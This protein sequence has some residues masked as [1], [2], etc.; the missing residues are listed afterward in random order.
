MHGFGERHT[1]VVCH[2]SRIPVLSHDYRRLIKE[3]SNLLALASM[4]FFW[5]RTARHTWHEQHSGD[6]SKV[7]EAHP[8]KICEI[9]RH[10]SYDGLQRHVALAMP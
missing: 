7:P 10:F 3:S 8:Q 2:Y 9:L 4:K 5:L 6:S 1:P